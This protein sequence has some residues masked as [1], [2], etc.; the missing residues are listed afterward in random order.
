MI[1]KEFYLKLTEELEKVGVQLIAV[2]KRQPI[3]SIKEL[4]DL[5][6]RDFGENQVQELLEKRKSLPQDIQWHMIG[7]LQRNK[8]KSI[9]PFVHMIHAV[10]SVRLYNKIKTEANLVGRQINVL[11]QLKIGMEEAKYGFQADEI[12]ELVKEYDG[13]ANSTIQIKGLMGM[14]S[15]TDDQEQVLSEFMELTSLYDKLNP[16]L[17]NK[18]KLSIRSIGMSSDYPLAIKAGGN[19]IRIGSKIFGAR[20]Y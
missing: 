19:M 4:Y 5:G 11:L 7:H 9:I 2:S 17:I 12:M 8:V 3:E 10:D 13:E 20:K 18:D 1:N 6:H 16:I 15:Y 14:A